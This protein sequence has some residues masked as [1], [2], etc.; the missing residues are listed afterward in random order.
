MVEPV[1]ASAGV[2]SSTVFSLRKEESRSTEDLGSV[3]SSSS[4][5]LEPSGESSCACVRDDA[6]QTCVVLSQC[7]SVP[8][9]APADH[10]P[11]PV[12]SS[13]GI[14][15]IKTCPGQEYN[16]KPSYACELNCSVTGC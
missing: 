9:S 11:G 10:F 8:L 1:S 4:A 16:L 12:F 15:S 14:C 2:T 6:E 5:M 7:T 3:G 13:P